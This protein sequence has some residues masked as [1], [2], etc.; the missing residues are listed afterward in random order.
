MYLCCGLETPYTLPDTDCHQ[1]LTVSSVDHIRATF[2]VSVCWLVSLFVSRITQKCSTDFFKTKFRWKRNL[3][4]YKV[5]VE[6]IWLMFIVDDDER[7]ASS[8]DS[9][10]TAVYLTRCSYDGQRHHCHLRHPGL[11][12]GYVYL[13]QIAHPQKTTPWRVKKNWCSFAITL[14]ALHRL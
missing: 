2:P 11:V 7:P 8:W 4:G 6:L 1:N 14:S 9:S 10:A 12:A 3:G 13:S 5:Q